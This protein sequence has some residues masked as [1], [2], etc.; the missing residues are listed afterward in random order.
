MNNDSSLST[1]VVVR[2][3][4]GLHARPADMLVRLAQQFESTIKIGKGGEHVD[5]KSILSLLTLGA[6]AGT[7]L[8]VSAHGSDAETAVQAIVGLFEAGFEEMGE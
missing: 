7:E 4:Q 2:N 8:S 1:T 3:P 5:C 6:A